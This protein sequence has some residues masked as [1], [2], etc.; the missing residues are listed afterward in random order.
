MTSEVSCS[1]VK[2]S[3]TL[4]AVGSL[5]L[6]YWW[7]ACLSTALHFACLHFSPTL[8]TGKWTKQTDQVTHIINIPTEDEPTRVSG[9]FQYLQWLQI[10][11]D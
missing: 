11:A 4:A 6:P 8:H 5:V 1:S 3:S 10:T 7:L 2:R 9:R